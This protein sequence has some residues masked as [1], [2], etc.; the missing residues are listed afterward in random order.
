[1]KK[2]VLFFFIITTLIISSLCNAQDNKPKFAMQNYFF[3]FLNKGQY[4]TKDTAESRRLFNGHMANIM[5]MFEAGKLKLAG[6][7]MDEGK[8]EGIFILD[9]ATEEE[10]RKLLANDPLIAI[11][12]LDAEIRPWYGPKGLTV[13]P[14]K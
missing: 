9:V 3:V 1:M 7:F 13:I 6:P 2:I 8:T 14:D 5:T 10:A 11:G 4:S 12:G